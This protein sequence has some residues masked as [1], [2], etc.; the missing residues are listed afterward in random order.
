MRLPEM[1]ELNTSRD[2]LD[3]F[4]GYNHNLRIGNGEFFD[5]KNLTSSHYPVLSPRGKRGVY[6]E[7]E[8][9]QGLVQYDNLCYVDGANLIVNKHPVA[10]GLSVA[11]EDCPKQLIRM[12]AYIIIMPDKK[13]INLTDLTDFGPIEAVIGKKAGHEVSVSFE[14]CKVDGSMHENVHTSAKAPTITDGAEIPLWLDTSSKPHS[15][16]QYSKS[17]SSW[18][19]IATTYVKMTFAGYTEESP[20]PFE[21]GD[22]V[23]IE[24]I[25]NEQLSDLNNTMI[26]WSRG[27]NYIV[28]TGICDEIFT[29][30]TGITVSRL[31]P[32]MDFVIESGNRLWG[33]RYGPARNGEVVNEIYASKLGDFRNWNCFAGISTDSWVGGV[34]TDG[35]FTGA[36]THLGYPI[37][38]KERYMHKVYGNYPAN[39]QINTTACRGVQEGSDKSLAIVNEV[40]YYKSRSAVCAYDGSLPMEIS[41]PLGDVTY[42]DAVAG[43]HGNKYYI[44]MH[45]GERGENGDWSLFVYDASK[46]MWHKEDATRAAAFCSCRGE[47]YFIDSSDKKI[48]TVLGSGD[49][50]ETTAIEWMAETGLIATDSPDHKY[51]SKL[52]IRMSLA[53]GTKVF[54]FAEYDSS[55]TWEL[56][57]D[58][59]STVLR[60]FTVTIKPK[61]CD[62]LRLR[63]TGTGEAKIFSI[64]K[65]IEEG[66]DWK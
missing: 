32:N 29:Q 63:I 33:C 62:H 57:G 60:S 61:R 44:S 54:V 8:N 27:Y 14:M 18:T 12:G 4:K 11:E 49:K 41:S 64:A 21:E 3:V 66:S 39:Y 56:L 50:Q 43:G 7:P 40:L 30:P 22:G 35:E 36:I 17:M 55:G 28:V 20:I 15:L 16:K 24:G 25:D 5:M 58:M 23:T 45:T 9:P 38:F 46:G 31:M 26:V 51:I 34:G 52:N 1:A 42:S 13:Y 37:F 2:L 19:T 10:M 59:P 53:A 6:A 48:K 65:T 47:L